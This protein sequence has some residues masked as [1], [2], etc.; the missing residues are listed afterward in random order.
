MGQVQVGLDEAFQLAQAEVIEI[1]ALKP[2]HV[3]PIQIDG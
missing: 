3:V 1:S 2:N